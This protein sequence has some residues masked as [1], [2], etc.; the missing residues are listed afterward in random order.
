MKTNLHSLPPFLSVSRSRSIA[1][2]ILSALAILGNSL[3]PAPAFAQK[4]LHIQMFGCQNAYANGKDSVLTQVNLAGG[5][6]RRW[7]QVDVATKEWRYLNDSDFKDY[8]GYQAM[9]SATEGIMVYSSNPNKIW[10]TTDGW[11]TATEVTDKVAASGFA[12]VKVTDEGYVGHESG[13]GGLYFSQDG[14]TWSM[15]LDIPSKAPPMDAKGKTVFMLSGG[16][17]QYVSSD[18]GKTFAIQDY[19]GGFKGTKFLSLKVISA[20]TIVYATD[21]ALIR[22]A[23]GGKTEWTVSD[24]PGGIGSIWWR[25][26]NEIW[27]T[28]FAGKLHMSPDRGATWKDKPAINKDNGGMPNLAVGDAIF[29][30][31]GYE[32]IDDGETWT[33]F[34]PAMQMGNPL[35]AMDFRGSMGVVGKAKGEILFTTDQGRSF[36]RRDTVGSED[37]MA[38]K[39]LSNG[40]ILAGDRNGQ[41]FSSADS[42]R[43][44][45]NKLSNYLPYNALKF[46]ASADENVIVMSRKGQPVVSVDHGKTFDFVTV[47]GGA[48]AWTVKPNGTLVQAAGTISGGIEI[49]SF[50]P[51]AARVPMDS[52][53]GEEI[54]LDMATS[55]ANVGYL[56]TWNSAAKENRVYKT[57]SGWAEVSLSASLKDAGFS[58]SGRV[59]VQGKDTVFVSGDGKTSWFSSVDGGKTFAAHVLPVHAA[60]PTEYPSIRIAWFHDANQAV[61]SLNNAGLWL[62]IGSTSGGVGIRGAVARRAAKPSMAWYDA[63][64]KGI[65]LGAQKDAR[66]EVSVF[67]C[68]GLEVAG[69]ANHDARTPVNIAHLPNGLYFVSVKGKS[70]KPVVAR[71]LKR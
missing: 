29:A 36:T 20:D 71:I 13:A 22:T 61:F 54:A 14:L 4:G 8:L 49:S 55:D 30:W 47:S 15:V 3:F 40:D 39:I 16:S 66:V 67:D 52:I 7:A 57:S 35:F 63:E 58:G 69:S 37:V 53:L 45:A 33:E 41:V 43:T 59:Q 28:D 17:Q 48:A 21:V 56:L 25:D 46:Q 32:S 1:A 44:W 65:R 34:L 18:G 64:A 12:Q 62:D 70:G 27:V 31:P 24:V 6:F 9:K 11:K 68:L 26:A 42:G 38:L 23:D 50:T 19:K 60:Y 51:K 2:A 10:K 5:K